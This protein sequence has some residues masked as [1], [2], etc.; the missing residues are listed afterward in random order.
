[1]TMLQALKDLNA[2][3]QTKH[4]EIQTDIH[5][6]ANKIIN[7]LN[8][9]TAITPAEQEQLDGIREKFTTIQAVVENANE[10]IDDAISQVL[11]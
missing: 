2:E 1:M 8:M 7:G 4:E 11:E 5:A 3:L 10:Q 6:M 9:A